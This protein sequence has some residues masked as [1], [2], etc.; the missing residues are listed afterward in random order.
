MD[1]KLNQ[2]EEKLDI[3]IA[4]MSVHPDFKKYV[5]EGLLNKKIEKLKIDVE[6][7]NHDIV[8]K[9]V[10]IAAG[11]IKNFNSFSPIYREIVRLNESNDHEGVSKIIRKIVTDEDFFPEI[12]DL[13]IKQL[14]EELL[15]I[16]KEIK[17]LKSENT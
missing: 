4:A 10:N 9:R 16:D 12:Y 14:P 5:K 8:F 3:I 17:K 2:I 6:N 15:D 11:I 13:V 7:K 1:N